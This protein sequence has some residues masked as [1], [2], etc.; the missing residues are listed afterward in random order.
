MDPL[1]PK[2]SMEHVDTTDPLDHQVTLETKGPKELLD[3]LDTL[4]LEESLV[5]LRT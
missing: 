2:V 5:P 4:D 1:G 3:L